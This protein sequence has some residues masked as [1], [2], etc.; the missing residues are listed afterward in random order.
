MY[1]IPKPERK[2]VMCTTINPLRTNEINFDE[3]QMT[4]T[5]LQFAQI[6]QLKLSRLFAVCTI[7]ASFALLHPSKAIIVFSIQNEST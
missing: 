3:H 5:Q 1:T 2:N 6:T 7:H 4:S